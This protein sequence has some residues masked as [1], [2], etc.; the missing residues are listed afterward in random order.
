MSCLMI[1]KINEELSIFRLILAILKD[2]IFMETVP[3]CQIS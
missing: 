3:Q 1:L 2:L